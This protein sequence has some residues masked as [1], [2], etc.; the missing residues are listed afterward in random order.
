MAGESR[1]LMGKGQGLAGA[2]NF[3]VCVARVLRMPSSQASLAKNQIAFDFMSESQVFD[4]AAGA[5]EN[6]QEAESGPGILAIVSVVAAAGTV[7][8]ALV[9][10][11][12]DEPL[13]LTILSSLAML[14]VFLIFAMAAGSYPYWRAHAGFGYSAL[15]FRGF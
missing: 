1:G 6:L 11:G 4:Q 10:G 12:A 3:V 8:L 9:A 2:A 14:G 5:A 15:A 7:V 13:M